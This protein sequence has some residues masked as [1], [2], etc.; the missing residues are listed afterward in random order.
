MNSET[1]RFGG[2]LVNLCIALFWIYLLVDSY[3]QG[4]DLPA[5]L[6]EVELPDLPIALFVSAAFA[7]SIAASAVTF[8]QRKNL[9]DEM[10]FVAERVDRWFGSGSYSRF[11]HRLHPVWA[12]IL[13]STVLGVVGVYTTYHL[14]QH[15]W[16]YAI[17]GGT[18]VFALFMFVAW[19]LSRRYPPILS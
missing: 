3:I 15:I 19:L 13:S 6:G 9:M 18:L 7:I 17:S 11:T 10:P 5:L 4:R 12:S 1:Q 16:S 2:I 8:W 14:N